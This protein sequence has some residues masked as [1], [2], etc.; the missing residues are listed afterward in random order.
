MIASQSRGYDPEFEAWNNSPTWANDN[1]AHTFRAGK[2]TNKR[3]CNTA[4]A[5]KVLRN[6]H[7]LMNKNS[8]VF[9]TRERLEQETIYNTL[10]SQSMRSWHWTS[11]Q[12]LHIH[13]C[14]RAN[15]HWCLR[16]RPYI[17]VFRSLFSQMEPNRTKQGL[18]VKTNSNKVW[19]IVVW[20]TVQFSSKFLM[21]HAV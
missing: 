21:T 19:E 2:K 7:A 10:F 5:R 16:S 1:D 4:Q 18:W 6:M 14:I 17:R 13:F 8:R 3:N 11:E 15:I 9:S 12:F 20:N